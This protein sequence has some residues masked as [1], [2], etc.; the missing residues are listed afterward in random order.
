MTSP[1]PSAEERITLAA[2]ECIERYGIA[3]ATNRR[4]SQMA[5][6]NAAA[7]NY[8][9]RSKANLIR[10]CKERTLENAFDLADMPP[11]PD[12]GPQERCAAIMV[13]LIE[14]GH[15]Y[16]GLTRAHFQDLLE[17]GKTEPLLEERLNRFV[18]NL[19]DDLRKRGST[20]GAHE[21][22]IALTQILS[23]TL[24][25]ILAPTLF[26]PRT[27]VDMRDVQARQA[28]V[29]RMVDRLLAPA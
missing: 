28:Y 2:I 18:E 13:D 6:V 5:G 19:A 25:A 29:R 21:L 26:A 1:P 4:I 11:M 24:I 16:P 8:Y 12:L 15:R 10:R 7:I 20:L 22:R 17:R 27:G 14:G 23:A 3:G 9:F